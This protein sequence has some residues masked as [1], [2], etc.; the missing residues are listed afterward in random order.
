VHTIFRA[1]NDLGLMFALMQ[2]LEL[3]SERPRAGPAAETARQGSIDKAIIESGL[4]NLWL[5]TS[6]PV[7]QNPSLV[8]SSEALGHVMEQLKQQF[9]FVILDSAPLGPVADSLLLATHTD[10]ALLVARSNK[11]RRP[12]LQRVIDSLNQT[13]CPVLGIVMN[14]LRLGLVER[15]TYDGYYG[16]GKHYYGQSG[17]G[18]Q[19]ENGRAAAP[20]PA[21]QRQ[22]KPTTSA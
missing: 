18:V 8:L 19:R 13:G 11:T 10:G 12:A 2:D 3:D 17:E 21:E 14:D 15:Y 16:Y 1:A 20:A 22:P 6:G 7:P 5:L 9:D 4:N